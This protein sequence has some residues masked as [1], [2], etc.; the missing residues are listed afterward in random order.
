MSGYVLQQ[1]RTGMLVTI[2]GATIMVTNIGPAGAIRFALFDSYNTAIYEIYDSE[3]AR[4]DAIEDL[5]PALPG[6][7]ERAGV[8]QATPYRPT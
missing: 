8:W 7:E 2:G 3:E 1:P 4:T 5:Y 6:V